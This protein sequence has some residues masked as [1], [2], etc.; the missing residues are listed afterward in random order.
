MTY[1]THFVL[2]RWHNPDQQVGREADCE[3]SLHNGNG[4]VCPLYGRRS[5]VRYLP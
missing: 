5:R 4:G 1:W 3:M 2:E